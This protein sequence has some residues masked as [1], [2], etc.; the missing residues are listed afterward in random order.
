M[1]KLKVL[2]IG[3]DGATY[4]L[5]NPLM[6]SGKLSTIEKLMATGCHG[7]LE[8]S[9]PAVTFPAWKCYSTGKNPGKLGV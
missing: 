3:L 6:E 1:K 4:N 7:D 5:I 2:V 9:I 8:S